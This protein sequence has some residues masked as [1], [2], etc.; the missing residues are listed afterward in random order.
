VRVAG[1]TRWA[2]RRRRPLIAAGAI[3]LV[4]AL[5][6]P[7]AWA[8]HHL[9]G[10]KRALAQ[11]HPEDARTHLA[12]AL[13]V[14]PDRADVRLLASRAA[15][16]AGDLAEADRQL[17]AAQRAAGGAT[18]EIAFEWALLQ[19]AA[20]NT[21]EVD[22]YLQTR[23]AEDPGRAPIVWEAL[24][25]GYLRLFRTLDA[26]ACVDH[27]LELDPDNVR[28]LEL[29][30]ITYVAGKGVQR[31]ATDFRRV[32]ELDPSRHETRWR[33]AL[34]LVDLGAYDEA[35]P[36]L[37][38]VARERP[39]DPDVLVRLAR[40]ENM[41]GRGPD[42]RRHLD[43]VLARHPDHPAALRTR[44]QFALADGN[45]GEA[46]GWL[47]RAAAAAPN[48][49]QAQYFLFQALQQQDKT[50]EARAQLR[51]TEEVKDRTE[52]LSELRSRKLTERPLDPALHYEM[53]ML[54][55]RTG[56]PTVGEAWL[57][58]AVALDPDY[59]PALAALAD[60]YEKAGNPAKAAE[61]RR[62]AGK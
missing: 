22:E 40:C 10:G 11:Y 1:L 3:A 2:R 6:G 57:L 35:L 23:A 50:A 49:Y 43:D 44:G 16:E 19:A 33:L 54:L 9:R 31:G 48:D 28:A 52:R 29:R 20:G 14:W 7:Q 5:G 21:W 51:V 53:G 17:R 58:S 30:G 61:H 41:L 36:V 37:E 27:W 55:I 8:W 4:L 38:R 15:R 25:E 42:A 59:T 18:A 46:E 34:C 60:L 12:G 13:A 39:D 24:I 56:S 26:M 62:L 45:P 32:V 47:R